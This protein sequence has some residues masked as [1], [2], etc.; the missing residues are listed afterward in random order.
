MSEGNFTVGEGYKLIVAIVAKGMASRLLTAVKKAG[1][2]GGT[3]L[4]W[5]GTASKSIYL[6][7]LGMNFEPEK[8][9]ILTGV[10]ADKV[11]DVLQ[12]I[13]NEGKINKPGKGISFVLNIKGIAGIVHLLK[14][15]DG[16]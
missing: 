9:I 6:D 11:D 1:A 12:V 5:R 14:H 7:L 8:E 10:K 16:E 15:N 4:L 2:E 3:I 13:V